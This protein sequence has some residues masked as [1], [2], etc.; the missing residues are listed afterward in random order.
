MSYVQDILY[1]I[2]HIGKTLERLEMFF[3]RK[4]GFKVVPLK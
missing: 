3:N 1:G 4:L 2:V